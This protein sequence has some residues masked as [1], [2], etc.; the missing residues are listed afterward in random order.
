M[1]TAITT[2]KWNVERVLQI[3]LAAVVALGTILLGLGQQSVFLP[4][5]AILAAVG[6]VVLTDTMGVFRLNRNIANVAALIAVAYALTDFFGR[7]DSDTQ[8]LAVANLLV[9]LQ[10]V[11]QF[12]E[13]SLRIYWSLSVLSLLQVVVASALNLSVSFGLLLTLYLVVALTAMSLLFIYRE[14]VRFQTASAPPAPARPVG[15]DRRWPLER[16]PTQWSGRTI[17]D[18]AQPL[19]GGRLVRHVAGMGLVTLLV[20]VFIFYGVPRQRQRAWESPNARNARIVGF[21]EEV[22]LG[23]MGRILQSDDPVLRLSF[24]DRETDEPIKLSGEPYLRGAALSVYNFDAARGRG[25]WSPWGGGRESDPHRLPTGGEED[26]RVVQ[27]ITLISPVHSN[28]TLGK[29]VLFSTFPIYRHADS[30]DG[31][32]IDP[33]NRQLKIDRSKLPDGGRQFH[34]VVRTG[35]FR[36]QG[37]LRYTHEPKN[38]EENTKISRFNRRRFPRLAELAD[39]IVADAEATTPLEKAQAL[40]GYL[41]MPNNFEYSLSPPPTPR[42]MDPIE[43]FV[44]NHRTGHCEYF[45]SALVLMLRS[46]EIPARMVVGYKGGAFNS[47]GNY[48]LVRQKDAHAWVEAYLGPS[49]YPSD[50]RREGSRFP[51]SDGVWLRLE[52]TPADYI[53]DENLGDATLL[54]RLADAVDYTQLLWS[55]Y[56]LGLNAER[57]G[58]AIYGPLSQWASRL[59]QAVA[60]GKPRESLYVWQVGAALLLA[61]LAFIACCVVSC[62]LI[63]RQTRRDAVA[64]LSGKPARWLSGWLDFRQRRG[65][66][67]PQVHVEFYQR[68][69][70]LLRRFGITR[71]PHQTHRE[72]A[73][74]AGGRLADVP[75]L[76]PVAGLP[77]RLVEA[78]YRVRFGGAVLDNTEA[79]AIEQALRDLE[80]ALRRRDR[81]ASTQR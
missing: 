8:L 64:W 71:Q 72:F 5:V 49:E 42:G 78:F 55:E 11:L 30:P 24:R 26:G 57:Q 3:S 61:V 60:L 28:K 15:P 6:S 67:R 43:D 41:R 44:L 34:Y 45:A 31:L 65:L 48:Y 21:S 38:Q 19:V 4:C 33:F 62:V 37:Q 39:R 1:E 58:E 35:A 70:R 51:S 52:P 27:D 80:A 68:L 56:V 18:P 63:P 47:L 74:A 76:Q 50:V 32:F 40:E 2:T 7:T 46:Q 36:G 14:T 54:T 66:A 20:T 77:K 23:E 16:G 9:Y 29:A 81:S 73:A 17:E 22:S 12:Q 25:R 75:H 10:V 79:Q 69:E 13:K 53:E 59:W